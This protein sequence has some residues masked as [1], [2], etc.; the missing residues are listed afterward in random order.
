MEH[1]ECEW[2]DWGEDA[3]ADLEMDL[4]DEVV[5]AAMR[6][7]E[8]HVGGDMVKASQDLVAA[9]DALRE[10]DIWSGSRPAEGR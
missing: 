6:W 3:L 7:N 5:G 1:V 10:F 4:R 2:D 9:A 8:A